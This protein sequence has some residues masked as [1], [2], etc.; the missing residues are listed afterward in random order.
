MGWWDHPAG[1]QVQKPGP[2]VV[3]DERE[4]W[5]VDLDRRTCYTDVCDV[6][7]Q[8]ILRVVRNK[9]RRVGDGTRANKVH[10]EGTQGAADRHERGLHHHREA[11]TEIFQRHSVRDKLLS[12]NPEEHTDARWLC[13]ARAAP[14][15]EQP[16]ILPHQLCLWISHDVKQQQEIMNI[17][18]KYVLF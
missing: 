2:A 16:D 8:N 18:Y 9:E 1:G 17:Y 4:R 5:R 15:Q 11:S 7:N 3:C 14:E 12:V 13:D 6:R 10:L